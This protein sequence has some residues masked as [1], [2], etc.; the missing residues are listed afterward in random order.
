M[1]KQLL[2][3]DTGGTNTKIAIIS[4]TG[5]RID[6]QRVPTPNTT[7][8]AWYDL[9]L[10]AF[11][12]YSR[13]H[14]LSGLALSCPGAVD[15]RA[16]VIYGASALPYLHGPAI[17][18]DLGAKLPVPI[19]LVNDANAM[20][21]GEYWRG[22]GQ[23]HKTMA[24]VVLGTGIGGAIIDQGRLNLGAHLHGGE[25]GYMWMGSG[26]WSELASAGALI[27]R[28]MATGRALQ[29]LQAEEIL[30]QYAFDD[31]QHANVVCEWADALAT[32]LF[33]IQYAIDPDAIVIGGAIADEG[34]LAPIIEEAIHRLMQRVPIAK[35]VPKVILSQLGG[36]AQLY[37]AAYWHLYHQ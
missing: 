26:I 23:S 29:P 35:V 10:S 1:S 31:G 24:M 33:N 14:H 32:G 30:R 18:K 28:F 20:A 22:S 5:S 36:D 21:L 37:G 11:D 9:V 4:Q 7:I 6:Y 15:A 27:R 3:I 19:S 34:A 13:H 12:S 8:E 17:I 25:F 2:T 16:G